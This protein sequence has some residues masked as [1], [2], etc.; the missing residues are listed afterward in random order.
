MTLATLVSSRD[1]P[2][3]N[4]IL[5]G[6]RP[7]ADFPSV[8]VSTT[9]QFSISA[10]DGPHGPS[11]TIV[12]NSPLYSINPSVVDVTCID[13][14]G[15]E[16]RVGGKFREP[17]MFLGSQISH[18][19]IVILDNG[20]PRERRPGRDPP[21]RVHRSPA[22]ANVFPCNLP[23]QVV[24]NLFPLDEGNYV[25][26]EVRVGVGDVVDDSEAAVGVVFAVEVGWWRRDAHVGI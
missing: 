13:V 20:S 14:D 25:L 10:H 5:G 17:L 12:V 8:G 7:V 21:G 19:G 24:N 6:C 3:L 22:P 2:E 1:I 11:G 26:A 15:N 18:F 4:V 23:P 16:A 9:E